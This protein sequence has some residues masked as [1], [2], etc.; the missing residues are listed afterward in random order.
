MNDEGKKIG[1][2][3]FVACNCNYI[4]FFHCKRSSNSVVVITFPLQIL[5][6]GKGREFNPPFE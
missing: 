6:A 2:Q 1:A 5:E 3:K 4:S